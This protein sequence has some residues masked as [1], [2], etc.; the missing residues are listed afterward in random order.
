MRESALSGLDLKSLYTF[1]VMAKHL[2]LTQAGIELGIT[3]AAASQRI[4]AL[5]RHL[6]VKL[7]EAL[8]TGKG[9]EVVKALATE[10]EKPFILYTGAFS[11]LLSFNDVPHAELAME[12]AVK[13]TGGLYH[14]LRDWLAGVR[15]R[16]GRL[17]DALDLLDP[18]QT[19]PVKRNKGGA[20]PFKGGAFQP[21]AF[22]TRPDGELW[23]LSWDGRIYEMTK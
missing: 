18:N 1:W 10:Q 9:E 6:G 21:T 15:V 3:D 14:P 12:R 13:D 16:Q 23:I 11:L 8:A 17:D 22:T 5:E 2:S 20:N 4:K 7:Y 19:L